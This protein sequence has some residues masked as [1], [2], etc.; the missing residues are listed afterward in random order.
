MTCKDTGSYIKIQ[1]L[2]ALG[3]TCAESSELKGTVKASR[4]ADDIAADLRGVKVL[5]S[6]INKIYGNGSEVPKAAE[7]LMD[8]WYIADREGL[9]AASDLRASTRLPRDK[10]RGSSAVEVAAAVLVSSGRGELNEERM[11]IFI[12]GYQNGRILNE[13]ELAAFI[14]ILK[15]ALITF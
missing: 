15:A 11:S 6:R 1:D 9:N 4:I 14:P 13:A 3:K 7:W 8:N 2:P 5:V 12:D 10:K